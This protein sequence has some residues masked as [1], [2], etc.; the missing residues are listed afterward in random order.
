[1]FKFSF[2]LLAFISKYES[3]EI[4]L[5]QKPFVSKDNDFKFFV[6]KKIDCK[7]SYFLLKRVA[8]GFNIIIEARPIK[9]KETNIG[10]SIF[11]REIPDVLQTM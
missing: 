9:K 11:Q 2:I 7:L 10:E 6:P 3:F 1:M 4:C 5:I 8:K